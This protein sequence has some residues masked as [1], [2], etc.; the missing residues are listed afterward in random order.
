V[1]V[2]NHPLPQKAVP[3]LFLYIARRPWLFGSVFLIIIGAASAA[4]SVQYAM[5]LLVDAMDSTVRSSADVWSPLCLFLALITI[6]NL[7]WRLG[8]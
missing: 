5:K 7:L 2:T 1:N 6:E 4:V 3:F 8:G